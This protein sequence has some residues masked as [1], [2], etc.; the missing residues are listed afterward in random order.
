MIDVK[1]SY[2][3]T[4]YDVAE[5]IDRVL[6]H[7]PAERLSLVPDCGFSQTAGRSRGPSCTPWSTDG[8]L[9]RGRR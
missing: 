5:R 8:D 2:V 6:E 1:N 9:V 4:A 7:V 3:E